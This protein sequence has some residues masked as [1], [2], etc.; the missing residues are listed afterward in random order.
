MTLFGRWPT[1]NMNPGPSVRGDRLKTA[2][3][4]PRVLAVLVLWA[5]AHSYASNETEMAQE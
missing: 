5:R 1:R 4:L 3:D 2:T